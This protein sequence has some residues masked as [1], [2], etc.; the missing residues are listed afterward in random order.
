VSRLQGK[1]APKRGVAAIL[2]ESLQGEGGV[3]PGNQEFF[4]TAR[5]VCD[6]SGALLMCDEV[7]TGELLWCARCPF[8]VS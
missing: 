4:Q 6:E 7:I 5:D 3:K 8:D 2:L 1:A